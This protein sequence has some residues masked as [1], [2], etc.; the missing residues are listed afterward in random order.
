MLHWMRGKEKLPGALCDESF[1]AALFGDLQPTDSHH[2]FLGES[3][4]KPLDEL[5]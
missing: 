3:G 5:L 2:L 1:S 4:V